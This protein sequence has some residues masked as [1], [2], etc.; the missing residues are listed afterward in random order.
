MSG[1]S[2]ICLSTLS[3]GTAPIGTTVPYGHCFHVSCFNQV[4][5]SR[6]PMCNQTTTSFC[7][8]YLDQ[9]PTLQNITQTRVVSPEVDRDT[10][11][12]NNATKATY[13]NV[14]LN[15]P[16]GEGRFR[17]VAKGI[18]TEGR[19]KGEPAVCKWFKTAHVL[20]NDFFKLDIKAINKAVELV[21]LWNQEH[22]ISQTIKLNV[23]E[24][25]TSSPGSSWE[26][27]KC[28][29]EPFIENY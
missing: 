18:Y 24:V 17:Y 23:A 9:S 6:C 2:C 3:S 10:A 27:R 29:N 7:R 21:S 14:A 12:R 25:W 22:F 1:T 13:S 11:R 15:N 4:R 26:G 19:R 8:I 16:F 5:S 28:L 20:E